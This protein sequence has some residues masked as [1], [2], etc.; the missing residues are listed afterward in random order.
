MRLRRSVWVAVSLALSSMCALASGGDGFMESRFMPENHVPA[1]ELQDYAAG[2][3][4]IVPGSF[5]HVYLYLAWRNAHGM[6][7]D[8][9]T[10]HSLGIR[11]WFMNGYDTVWNSDETQLAVDEWLKQR[12]QVKDAPALDK[13]FI[14]KR[15]PNYDSFRNCPRDT[16]KTA[17]ATLAAR[18]KT[19]RPDEVSFWVKAQDAV[20]SRCGSAWNQDTPENRALP[21]LP[22]TASA[23]LKAD[24]QY[25]QAAALFYEGNFADARQRFLAIAADAT[26]PWRPLGKYLAARSLL[27]QASL[28]TDP[29]SEQR[30]TLLQRARQEFAAIAA[31]YSPAARMVNLV[32]TWLEPAKRLR[33][34][35]QVLSDPKQRTINPQDLADYLSLLDSIPTEAGAAGEM[36]RWI[37]VM[38]QSA[39]LNPALMRYYGDVPESDKADL[40]QALATARSEWKRTG[41]GAWLLAMLSSAHADEIRADELAAAEQIPQ[42][43]PLW[44]SIAWHRARVQLM[45]GDPARADRIVD[46]ALADQTTSPSTRNR[47]LHLK[48]LSAATVE[49]WASSLKRK[50]AELPEAEP[51]P[52]EGKGQPDLVMDIDGRFQLYRTMPLSR[53]VAIHDAAIL[54]AQMKQDLAQKIWVRAVL[55]DAHDIARRFAGIVSQQ[56]DNKVRPALWQRY[57]AA[58][59][60]AGRK[61]VATLILVE[62]RDLDP[63]PYKAS[64]QLGSYLCY[65]A[66]WASNDV[67]VD[68]EAGMQAL[69]PAFLSADE[70]TAAVKEV[71]LLSA[72]PARAVHLGGAVINWAGTHLDDPDAPRVLHALVGATR[73][74]CVNGGE[75]SKKAFR[76]L[77]SKWPKSE[78]AR[79]TPYHY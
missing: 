31:V 71:D 73:P 70:R 49:A 59:D 72:L 22:A 18:L 24:Y 15:L 79:A 64:G 41:D 65:P 46:A 20:F 11:S 17:S 53:L 13:L 67:P 3:L 5:W 75:V 10:L 37:N 39:K 19:G 4:G 29:K 36:T 60:D 47:W 63:A 69:A 74:S 33:Q 54:P 26:S 32:D 56:P 68:P 6:P 7:I 23:W 76:L 28:G 21:V 34:L 1:N 55:L 61:L 30:V 25:Q 44:H 48:T 50:V 16:F 42:T 35:D 77:H 66:E 38:S 40:Q 12:T 52:D 45:K 14:D 57:A 27:R 62:T 8:A 43:S 58:P 78:W 51:I 2:R 9:Q